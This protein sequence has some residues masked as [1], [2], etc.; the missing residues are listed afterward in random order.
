M[1]FL[2]NKIKIEK[3]AAD[4]F[5]RAI[6]SRMSLMMKEFDSRLVQSD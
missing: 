5:V 1:A 3:E 6:E 4:I 2:I